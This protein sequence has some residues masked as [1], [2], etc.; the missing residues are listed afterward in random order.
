MKPVT[1]FIAPLTKTAFNRRGFW[2]HKVLLEWPHIIGMPL[3]QWTR[4]EKITFPANQ[5]YNGTLHLLTASSFSLE[6]QHLSPVL[7]DKVNTYFGYEALVHL[8]IKQTSLASFKNYLASMQHFPPEDGQI[9]LA[10]EHDSLQN[11]LER[12]SKLQASS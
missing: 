6:V 2:L 9:P 3:S 10:L 11:V 4:P 8:T 1:N 5:R 12:L 7:L